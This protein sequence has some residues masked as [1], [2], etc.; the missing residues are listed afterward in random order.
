MRVKDYLIFANCRTGLVS[1]GISANPL[2]CNVLRN[3]L[4]QLPGQPRVSAQS[5]CN[6]KAVI[7]EVGG[8]YSCEMGRLTLDF[9]KMKNI[10]G[11]E[12]GKGRN[13]VGT[14]AGAGHCDGKIGR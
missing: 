11:N 12:F 4:K 10:R 13:G 3:G 6:G 5:L 2:F 1:C 7:G 14:I 9:S 8:E